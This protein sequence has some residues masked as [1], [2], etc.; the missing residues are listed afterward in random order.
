MIHWG[1]PFRKMITGGEEESS[2]GQQY[3]LADLDHL[4]EFGYGYNL[5]ISAGG[6]G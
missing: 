2:L 3:I 4:G 5:K 6:I 1:A